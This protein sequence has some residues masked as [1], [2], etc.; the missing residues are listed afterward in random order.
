MGITSLAPDCHSLE[1]AFPEGLRLDIS[2]PADL[3]FT[4]RGKGTFAISVSTED[5]GDLTEVKD[6]LTG[7]K[8]DDSAAANADSVMSGM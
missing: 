1:D 7:H 6:D 8:C 4:Y 5:R 3:I 2:R